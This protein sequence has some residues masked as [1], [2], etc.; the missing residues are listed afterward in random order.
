MK[1]LENRLNALS[2][3]STTVLSENERL[4]REL[5]KLATQNEILRATNSSGPNGGSQPFRPPSPVPGPQTYS[6]TDFQRAVGVDPKLHPITYLDFGPKEGGAHLLSA[7]ATWDLIQSHE[8]SRKGMVDI[9]DVCRR[10]KGRATCNGQG[11]AFLE[12]QVIAA[13]EESVISAADELI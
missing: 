2:N 12:S 6:P 5:Q 13:I 9:G 3:Q 11:P 4:K 1:D 10:L 7:G 8:L